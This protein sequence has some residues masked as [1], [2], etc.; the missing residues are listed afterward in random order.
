MYE[1]DGFDQILEASDMEGFV[2]LLALI[3]GIGLVFMVIAG[4]IA[5]VC[6]IFRSIGLY[7]MANRRGIQNAWLVW[8]PYGHYWIAGSL[9]DQYQYVTK[10]RVKN[11]RFILL[12]LAIGTMVLSAIVQSVSS[13]SIGPL[14]ESIL[15]GEPGEI[16]GEIGMVSGVG[17]AVSGLFG[18]LETA[19]SIAL[20]VFWQISLY[21]L[22]KSCKPQYAVLFLVLGIIFGFTVPFFLFACRNKDEGMPPRRAAPTVEN[23]VPQTEWKPAAPASE[24][25]EENHE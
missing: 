16:S 25:W 21:D 2:G 6:Y 15:S 12:A 8:V 7:T 9:S 22:Y 17:V 19:A 4:I 5:I 24:P 11:N 1:I 13:T 14:V 3:L 10:G 18:L 20:Y 23:P